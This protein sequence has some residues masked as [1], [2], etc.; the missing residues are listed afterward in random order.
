MQSYKYKVTDEWQTALNNEAGALIPQSPKGVLVYV[1]AG[2]PNEEN[3]LILPSTGWNF[4]EAVTVH[5]R[6]AALGQATTLGVIK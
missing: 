2:T 1:G 4:T 5:Y 6:N 3:G